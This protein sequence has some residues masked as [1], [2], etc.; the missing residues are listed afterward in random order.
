[1]S[2]KLNTEELANPGYLNSKSDESLKFI[3]PLPW[4]EGIKGRGK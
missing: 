2:I 3:F 4:R 1:M